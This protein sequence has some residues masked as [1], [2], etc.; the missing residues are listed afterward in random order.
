[1]EVMQTVGLGVQWDEL[2]SHLYSGSMLDSR[3]EIGVEQ[4]QEMIHQ[5][6]NFIVPFIS[7]LITV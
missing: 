6:K 7:R 5:D 1:M 3:S 4:C 2:H